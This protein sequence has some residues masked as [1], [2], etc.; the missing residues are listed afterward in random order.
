MGEM[1]KSDV[2]LTSTVNPY[3]LPKNHS[4]HTDTLLQ[5]LAGRIEG[6]SVG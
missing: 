3:G 4:D 2:K 6:R 5:N 1:S